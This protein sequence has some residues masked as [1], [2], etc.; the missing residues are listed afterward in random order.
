LIWVVANEERYF[1]HPNRY[2]EQDVEIPDSSLGVRKAI[3]ITFGEDRE[4][5]KRRA[6]PE[7]GGNPDRYICE[8]LTSKEDRVIFKLELL[9][10]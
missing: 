9:G 5:A 3:C 1:K 7:L 4:E 6:H 8:P 2:Y 10:A